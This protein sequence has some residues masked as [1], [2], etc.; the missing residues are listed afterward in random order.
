MP[1]VRV[2][3]QFCKGCGLCVPVCPKDILTLSDSVDRRGIHVVRVNREVVCTGCR[4]CVTMCP[5]AALEV[6]P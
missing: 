5:D 4:N 3:E 2:L 1:E 6:D